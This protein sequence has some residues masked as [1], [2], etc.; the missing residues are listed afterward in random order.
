[1]EEIVTVHTFT[2]TRNLHI[3]VFPNP[4]QS[5]FHLKRVSAGVLQNGRLPIKRNTVPAKAG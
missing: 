4:Q 2:A 5:R 3:K 1:M